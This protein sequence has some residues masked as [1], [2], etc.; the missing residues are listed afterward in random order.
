MNKPYIIG[1]VPAR[2]GSSRFPGKPL[3]PIGGLPMLGHV[4]LRARLSPLLD[5]LYIATCDVEIAD[6][7]AQ[8]GGEAIMTSPAHQRASDRCAEALTIVESRLGRKAD[9]VVMIQGDEPM[10]HPDMIGE[11]LQPLLDDPGVPVSNL[12]APLRDAEEQRDANEVKVVVDM[13]ND[14]LYFSREPIPTPRRDGDATAN[15][16]QVCIIPFRRDFLLTYRDLP[17]TPL[18]KAESV[19]MLRVLEHGYKVRMVPTRFKVYSVD[20]EADRARVERL[21]TDDPLLPVYT[22]AYQSASNSPIS[23]LNNGL[24]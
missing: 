21:M 23:S 22:G 18:E 10:L 3:A 12:M 2:M 4:Y 17:P 20:T 9:I 19:D 16:K 13:N 7:I 24:I 6:Y 14:A 5:G 8:I 11:A 1:I 15:W